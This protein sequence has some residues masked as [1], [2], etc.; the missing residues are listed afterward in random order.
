MSSE[1]S[2]PVIFATQTGISEEFA[3]NLEE[4]SVE[5]CGIQLK[6]TSI[7]TITRAQ[8]QK[9]RL[10]IFICSSH[11][12]GEPPDAATAF[13]SWLS[14]AAA[15]PGGS[16]M[17]QH[18]RFGLL[19][20]GDRNYIKWQGFPRDLEAT[21]VKLG[22]TLFHERG[23]ADNSQD[24]DEDFENWKSGGL[25]EVL[26][27]EYGNVQGEV[28]MPGSPTARESAEESALARKSQ[29]L[30]ASKEGTLAQSDAERVPTKS[31]P[32]FAVFRSGPDRAVV[33]VVTTEEC[34]P[35]AAKAHECVDA[36]F[37][38]NKL[39]GSLKRLLSAE[40]GVRLFFFLSDVARL[41]NCLNLE[42]GSTLLANSEALV[43]QEQNQK[44]VSTLEKSG[45]VVFRAG[46][47][48]EVAEYA[49][50]R[51][52]ILDAGGAGVQIPAADVEKPADA[53]MK[54]KGPA[55][56]AEMKD[57]KPADAEMRDAGAAGDAVKPAVT[58]KG[59]I[60]GSA[61]AKNVVADGVTDTVSKSP[62]KD[63]NA[64]V[65]E[66]RPSAEPSPKSASKSTTEQE[67][68]QKQENSPKS[69]DEKKRSKDPLQASNSSQPQTPKSPRPQATPLLTNREVLVSQLHVLLD[70]LE[71]SHE[72]TVA[73]A[74]ELLPNAKD[75]RRM[76]HVEFGDK[77]FNVSDNVSILAPSSAAIFDSCFSSAAPDEGNKLSKLKIKEAIASPTKPPKEKDSHS[78]EKN[79]AKKGAALL[80]FV[81]EIFYGANAGT[82][83]DVIG[84]ELLERL[85]TARVPG[86]DSVTRFVQYFFALENF[87]FAKKPAAAALEQFL[88]KP[89]PFTLVG[90]SGI[91][92]T[93]QERGQASTHLCRHAKVGEKMYAKIVSS[94]LR[95]RDLDA[96]IAS[97]GAT[98][99]AGRVPLVMIATGAG[100]GVFVGW[101]QEF[102]RKSADKAASAKPNPGLQ[103]FSDVTLFAGCRCW[104]EVPYRGFL[105]ELLPK[106]EMTVNLQTCKTSGSSAEGA[107]ASGQS[108]PSAAAPTSPPAQPQPPAAAPTSRGMLS[109]PRKK[110]ISFTKLSSSS[111][112]GSPRANKVEQQTAAAAAAAPSSPRA[113]PSSPR[114]APS[115]PPAVPF[116]WHLALS[117]EQV[118]QPGL[119]AGGGAAGGVQD[120]A[121]GEK[122]LYVQDLLYAKKDFLVEKIGTQKGH[123]YFC[124]EGKMIKD[125]LAYLKKILPPAAFQEKRIVAEHWGTGRRPSKSGEH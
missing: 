9:Q 69:A 44:L 121:G 61:A 47:W 83:P 104:D 5:K 90:N 4:E 115:S 22:A 92:V 63:V 35:L 85:R 29:R 56:S 117:R 14:K 53:E 73:E 109:T 84:S 43:L 95:L 50:D 10:A 71:Q 87:Y 66:Q 15:E 68:K 28:V 74:K 8:L 37:S 41:A 18:L 12:D 100:M 108:S 59:Q 76:V 70:F 105:A 17:L 48:A 78:S 79:T 116:R 23:E 40:H 34:A 99:N 102:N 72:L 52:I 86:L 55:D 120:G 24:I 19:G 39:M 106:I 93:H 36:G 21:L 88:N 13:F 57:E 7:T 107:A 62:S 33:E 89:R 1:Q 114:A 65:L 97:A 25:W 49:K 82:N 64:K 94:P 122:K 58:E 11:G 113:A 98:A 42:G 45:C 103:R 77:G 27:E 26:K 111:C 96:K 125:C 119:P 20:L 31:C 118:G 80:C 110:M 75:P 46:S 81:R 54:D 6:A 91:C 16:A 32:L 60:A 38:G 51:G 112:L 67:N 101:L 30:S 123:L 3:Q 124:G 2:I